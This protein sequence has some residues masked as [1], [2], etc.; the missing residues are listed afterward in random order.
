MPAFGAASL[1]VSVTSGGSPA[2]LRF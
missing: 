2:F 1:G